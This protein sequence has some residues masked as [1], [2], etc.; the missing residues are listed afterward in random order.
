MFDGERG[1]ESG[2]KTHRQF[3]RVDPIDV[4][5]KQM[6][7]RGVGSESHQRIDL[8]KHSQAGFSKSGCHMHQATIHPNECMA[9]C[10]RCCDGTKVAVADFD[11]AVLIDKLGGKGSDVALSR[12]ISQK[13]E[14]RTRSIPGPLLD[15][16]LKRFRPVP[17]SASRISCAQC[18]G[19]V[20]TIPTLGCFS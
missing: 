3:I 9:S 5:R 19:N 15:R 6:P 16:L 17:K 12:R 7:H 14:Q 13:H 18:N 20:Q 8:G 1:E 10:Q 11:P 4:L 2:A